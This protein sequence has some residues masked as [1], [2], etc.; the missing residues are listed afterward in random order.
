MTCDVEQALRDIEG[1]GG[2][3]RILTSGQGKTVIETL[4]VLGSLFRTTKELNQDSPWG[5]VILPGSGINADNVGHILDFLLHLGLR[6]IHLSGANWVEGDMMFRRVDMGMGLGNKGE[7]GIW[8][9]DEE[10]VRD[11][12]DIVDERWERF[13]QSMEDD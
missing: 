13:V 12:R 11:V 1:I 6:E 5:L 4:P 7:W 10:T 3:S 9:T 2:I 8:L